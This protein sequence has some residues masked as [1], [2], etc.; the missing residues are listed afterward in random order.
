M[1]LDLRRSA[2]V[3]LF[4]LL[5]VLCLHKDSILT[6]FSGKATTEKPGILQDEIISTPSSLLLSNQTVGNPQAKKGAVKKGAVKQPLDNALLQWVANNTMDAPLRKMSRSMLTSPRRVIV[7]PPYISSRLGQ[8]VAPG[9]GSPPGC[10]LFVHLPKAAGTTFAVFLRQIRNVT[11]WRYPNWYGYYGLFGSKSPPPSYTHT[12]DRV[13]HDGHVTPAF[14]DLTNGEACYTVT[15][16]REPVDRAISAFY[17]HASK[18]AKKEPWPYTWD[19][20][21]DESATNATC[22]SA[23]EYQNAMVRQYSD[24]STWNTYDVGAFR[25]HAVDQQSL[26]AAKNFLRGMNVVCFMHDLQSCRER[27]AAGAIPDKYH[28]RLN[29]TKASAGVKRNVNKHKKVT[30][31]VRRKLVEA[32]KLDIQLYEWA[33]SEFG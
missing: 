2:A 33:L 21:L 24:V 3:A 5:G 6:G 15:I 28:Q 27:V 16:L 32:N 7:V 12:S 30:D 8:H 13:I 20:C 31:E 19:A 25:K 4:A 22:P 29:I 10:I 26:Q 14:L 1:C 23:K 17:Y 11:G 18:Q 9:P